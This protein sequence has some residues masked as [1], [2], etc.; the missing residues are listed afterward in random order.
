MDQLTIAEFNEMVK[1]G[2]LIPDDGTG[3][4]AADDYKHI[5]WTEMD[6][7]LTFGETPPSWATHVAW[8]NK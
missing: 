8:Y 7:P 1:I 4:W 5:G 3:Y 6:T 2:A